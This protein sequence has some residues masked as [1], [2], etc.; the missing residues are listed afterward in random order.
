MTIEATW[1]DFFCFQMA[2]H[3]DLD[4]SPITRGPWSCNR[5]FART[6][7][8]LGGALP[9]NGAGMTFKFKSLKIQIMASSTPTSFI[10]SRVFIIRGDVSSKLNMESMDETALVSPGLPGTEE[11]QLGLCVFF[12]KSE[13]SNNNLV[14]GIDHS[15]MRS[16][17]VQSGQGLRQNF[18]R[19]LCF[20]LF[21]KPCTCHDGPFFAEFAMR[22]PQ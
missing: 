18:H 20:K 14:P 10:P 12:S 8:D 4:C 5:D 16:R 15:K 6:P 1:A 13:A 21:S 22:F 3:E 11:K 2:H 19:P 7:V 17:G 9:R